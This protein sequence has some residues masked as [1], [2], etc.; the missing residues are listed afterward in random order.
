[1]LQQLESKRFAL[2]RVLLLALAATAERFSAL[3]LGGFY[4][5]AIS[6]SQHRASGRTRR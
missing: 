3:R 1:M 6:R 5:L 4:S 2:M